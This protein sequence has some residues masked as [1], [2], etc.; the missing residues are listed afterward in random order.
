MAFHNFGYSVESLQK[1]KI[2]NLERELE[3]QTN[4]INKTLND[5][6]DKLET[7][8]NLKMPKA[9]CVYTKFNSSTVKLI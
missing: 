9:L 1:D 5:M 4:L 2:E 6:S 7:F 8:N 3:S